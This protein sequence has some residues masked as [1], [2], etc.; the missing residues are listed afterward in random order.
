MTKRGHEAIADALAKS[1]GAGFIPFLS[2]GDPDEETSFQL[3]TQLATF[4]S[5]IE[6]GIPY[7][8]PLADGPVIQEGSLRALKQGMT[9]QKALQLIARVRQVTDVPIV[10]FTYANPVVSF[11]AKALADACAKAG[12]DGVIVPDLP[13]EEADELRQALTARGIAL[14]PLVSL[15]SGDR[16]ETIA[17]AASGFIYCVSSLGVTGERK[18]FSHDLRA[19]VERVRKSSSV[20]VAVGFGVS[21]P[22]QVRELSAYTD[23]IVVGSALVKR[24]AAIADAKQ[25]GDAAALRE[26]NELIAFAKS[27]AAIAGGEKAR[28]PHA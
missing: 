18:G 23:G 2:A 28:D 11:G 27:L 26:Q 20:P 14:I 22:E 1:S 12:A 25:K 7:S 24:C 8:D 3:L 16:I 21:Q 9:F 15:T 4:S 13:H 5:V 6:V 17:R 19:F 10:V